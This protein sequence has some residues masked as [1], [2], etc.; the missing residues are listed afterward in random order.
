MEQLEQTARVARH[1]D[2]LPEIRA[3]LLLEPALRAQL[4]DEKARAAGN[5]AQ[6]VFV[7]VLAL[8]GRVRELLLQTAAQHG[9]QL[10][11]GQLELLPVGHA[12]HIERVRI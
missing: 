11:L 8:E 12:E 4:A 2:I 7:D 6:L 5:I 10:V 9:V 1:G 3:A